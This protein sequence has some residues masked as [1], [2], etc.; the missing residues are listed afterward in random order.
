LRILVEIR[1][2]KCSACE[3]WNP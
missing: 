2:E 1:S 3:A